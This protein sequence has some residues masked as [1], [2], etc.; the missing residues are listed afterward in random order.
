M[1]LS[2]PE[3]RGWTPG[4]GEA[5]HTLLEGLARS[6]ARFCLTR[7]RHGHGYVVLRI[8]FQGTRRYTG[9][10]LLGTAADRRHVIAE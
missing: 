2:L 3:T 5:A 10:W 9:C 4:F 8:P 6:D 7:C 1:L